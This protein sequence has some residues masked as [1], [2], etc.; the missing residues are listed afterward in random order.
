MPLELSAAQVQALAPDAA[1][2]AAGRKLGKP[3][4]WRTLGQSGAAIWG[5]C[6][7]SALYQTQVALSD[8]ASK[9]SC[10]SRKFPCKHALG[11]LFLAV[12]ASSSFAH[13]SEPEWVASWH[14]KREAS[15]EKKK[16]RAESA[17]E[18][19]VDEVAQAKRARKRQ[20]LVLA[21]LD[22][23]DAWCSDRIREGLS[24]LHGEGASVW[25]SQARRL[26][27]AQAP[28]L[29]SRL[30]RIGD[31]VGTSGDWTERT[32][33]ELGTIA[34]LTHAYRRL[35]ALS[36]ELAAD[37]RR[38]VGFT[39]DQTEVIA[40]GDLVEDEWSIVAD[41]LE[42]VDRVRMQRAWLH[43]RASGRLATLLQFAAGPTGRFAESLVPGTRFGARLA[44]WPSALPRRA[45]IVERI[46]APASRGPLPAGRA[47]GAN[48]EAFADS[49]ARLP[50]HD[51]ELLVLDRVVP[52]VARRGDATTTLLVDDEAHALPLRGEVHDLLLAVSG[53]HPIAVAGEWDGYALRAL[54]AEIE[55]RRVDLARPTG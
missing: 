39:L 22:Q 34:L 8:F 6:Q 48:L 40:H 52:V 23:L 31:E 5:E 21:G 7:G 36:P 49:L 24:R 11:L 50:W 42:E 2:A 37:V 17:A 32:L 45:L 12:D 46:G 35:D 29:A 16:A 53:G 55:G 54:V 51:R 15:D 30:R 44:F 1:S 9:C 43:G 13:V 10:P 18:K 47:V 28:A 19:P 25:E 14:A 38:L 33:H 4:P 27:D 26:V 20:E 3:A 41:V